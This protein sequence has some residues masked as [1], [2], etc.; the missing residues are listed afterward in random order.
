MKTFDNADCGAS[1]GKAAMTSGSGS[2]P[3]Q[4]VKLASDVYMKVTCPRSISETGRLVTVRLSSSVN[5]CTSKQFTA[6]QES[7]Q[8]NSCV[9]RQW[10]G[11]VRC[12]ERRMLN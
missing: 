11:H 9:Q 10:Q 12:C 6:Q 3:A 7:V 4:C 5:T 1:S 8:Q 2:F